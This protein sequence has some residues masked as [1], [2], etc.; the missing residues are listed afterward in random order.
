MKKR[1]CSLCRTVFYTNS[2]KQKYC[3]KE[4]AR[5]AHNAQRKVRDERNRNIAKASK[6]LDEINRQAR[7]AGMSYGKYVAKLYVE[8]LRNE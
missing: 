5:E 4:C 3:S 7:A 8:R 1:T 2:A 6:S